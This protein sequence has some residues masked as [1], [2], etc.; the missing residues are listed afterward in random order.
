MDYWNTKQSELQKGD[1]HAN[2]NSTFNEKYP[3]RQD[4]VWYKSSSG[5]M[6]RYPGK[7][8]MEEQVMFDSN[9]KIKGTGI[10]VENSTLPGKSSAY[11]KKNYTDKTYDRVY[12]LNS[13]T[14]EKS[15]QVWV[16]G[17]WIRFD[18]NGDYVDPK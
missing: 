1:I 5:Y 16:D 9:G 13:P 2:I 15:Y 11:L 14:G 3:E 6:A 7:N 4:A 10:Q 12:Q 18:S 17:K 8:N